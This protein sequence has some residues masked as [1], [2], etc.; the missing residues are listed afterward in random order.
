M[1][2]GVHYMDIILYLFSTQRENIG[3]ENLCLTSVLTVVRQHS[4]VQCSHSKLNT[5]FVLEADA[6]PDILCR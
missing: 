1:I 2:T 3:E 5:V 6:C 4:D